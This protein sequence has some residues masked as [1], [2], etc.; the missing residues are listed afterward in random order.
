M[1][2]IIG[3]LDYAYAVKGDAPLVVKQIAPAEQRKA[4]DA[5]MATIDVQ[6]LKIPTHV[7]DL[8][9]PR[10]M[11][12]RRSRESFKSKLGVAFD[13]FGAA[14]TASDLSFSFLLHPER[15]SRLIVNRSFNDKQLSLQ[16]VFDVLFEHS[17]KKTHKAVQDAELQQVINEQLL[18]NIFHLL[19]NEEVYPQVKAIGY[20]KLKEMVAYLDSNK[21]KDSE[22]DMNAYWAETIRKFLK[23]PS[24]NHLKVSPKIPD[25][26]PIGMD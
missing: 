12:N 20:K 2:K 11:G 21:S 14:A 4:L 15:V 16:E 22:N 26:S 1:T 25:G 10:A 7:L 3:G 19:S 24:S 23:N 17:L 9:P 18:Y 6:T 8:F 13:P 5:L